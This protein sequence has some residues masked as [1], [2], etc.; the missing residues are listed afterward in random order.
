MNIVYSGPHPEVV[1]DEFDNETVIVAGQPVDVPDDLAAR[2]LEQNT[3]AK[4]TAK[5]AK[6]ADSTAS[7]ASADTSTKAS[8]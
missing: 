1:V 6:A 2:L 8:N 4:A 3:W 5:Q 7:T